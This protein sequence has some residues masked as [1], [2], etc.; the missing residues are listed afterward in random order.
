MLS[1]G[2]SSSSDIPI[3]PERWREIAKALASARQVAI[4]THIH[5][6]GDALGSQVALARSLGVLGI[7][8]VPV[9]AEP[10]PVNFQ[11]LFPEGRVLTADDPRAAAAL[12]RADCIAVLDVSKS[13]RLGKLMNPVL[14]SAA[15][16]ICIDHHA[17]GDFPAHLSVVDPG[18]SSTG[19]L[20]YELG[21]VLLEGRPLTPDIAG[22]LYVAVVTDTGGF[23]YSNTHARTHRLAA[24]LVS[25]G[26]SPAQIHHEVYEKSRP[27]T[28]RLLGMAL[29]G[30]ETDAGGR[31]AWMVV[32]RDSLQRSGARQEDVDGFVEHP[33]S[34]AGVDVAVLFMELSSG[35]LKVSLRS[36][37]GINVQQLAARFGGGGHFNAAGILMDGPWD[38]ARQA[39]LA[40][41]RELLSITPPR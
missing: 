13:D 39:V 15:R 9:L 24:E 22:P 23:R 31:L 14:S 12:A 6:D 35:R 33:R 2:A 32:T 19:E 5:P 38:R 11:F 21:R 28:L 40:A 25:V 27:E 1:A 37:D 34:L 20:V 7:E 17:D 10:V 4:A 3:D 16:R 41:A 29:A 26:V 30:L 18:A 36:R 8:A